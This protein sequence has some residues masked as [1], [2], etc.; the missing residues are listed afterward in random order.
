[1][2]HQH[3]LV[4]PQTRA[5]KQVVGLIGGGADV[6]AI[7]AATT[8]AAET[9]M[10][11]ASRDPTVRQTFH[12]LT[13]LP[14]AAREND[15]ARALRRL[16]LSVTAQPG[17]VEIGTALMDAIDAYTARRGVRTDY[18]EIAQLSAV[19]SLNHVAGKQLSDFFDQGP[20]RTRS[21]LSQLAEGRRFSELAR[22]F[23]SR[24]TRRHLNFY[25]H[26]EM[27]NHVGV[28]R[29]FRSLAEHRDFEEALHRHCWEASRIIEEFAAQW[30]D[31]HRREDGI[32]PDKAGRFVHVAA[33]KIR[34]ELRQRE[35]VRA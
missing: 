8:R 28:A 4:I 21:A 31:K 16:G 24:L 15:F 18:G 33:G 29:R 9:S 35:P 19:E 2:G 1:M 22:V 32:G 10:I 17:L 23:F 6:S 34:D 26:R 14:L 11:D 13:Q 7:A 20:V 12:L 3:L 5:W 30:F 25:L 27:S